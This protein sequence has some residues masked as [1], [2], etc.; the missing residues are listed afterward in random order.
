MQEASIYRLKTNNWYQSHVEK[1][2]GN[3]DN[4]S[5]NSK[6]GKSNGSKANKKGVKTV[7]KEANAST[8]RA[9]GTNVMVHRNVSVQYPMLTDTNYG[10]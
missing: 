9:C 3:S 1:T 10:V 7:K 2:M 5:V 4:E 8:S 6:S